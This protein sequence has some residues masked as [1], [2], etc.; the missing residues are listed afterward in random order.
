MES[1]GLSVYFRNNRVCE[2]EISA[3]NS[4]E[5]AGGNGIDSHRDEF[6]KELGPNNSGGTS[7]GRDIKYHSDI[8][9][10]RGIEIRFIRPRSYKLSSGKEMTASYAVL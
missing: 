6:R 1:S 9:D 2:L 3:P 7:W 5:T 8:W 4:A 10:A